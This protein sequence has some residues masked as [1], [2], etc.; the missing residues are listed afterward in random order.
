MN[1]AFT[2]SAFRAFVRSSDLKRR[3]PELERTLAAWKTIRMDAAAARAFA[4][5]PA[6]ARIR[7]TIYPSIKP[8]TNTFVWEPRTN[9]AIF[10]YLDPEISAAQFD[11]TLAHELHHLGVASVCNSDGQPT[12]LQ[13]M[14]GFAEG[15][16]VLAAAGNPDAHPHE[17]SPPVERTVWNRDFAN[18]ARDMEQL[19][20]FFEELMAGTLKEEQQNARGFAFIATDS[21]PQGA[22]YTVGYHMA[23]TVEKGLGRDRLIAS[24]CDPKMF[25]RDYNEIAIAQKLP[26]WSP[27]FMAR[28]ASFN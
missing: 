22:F 12:A 24:L 17:T 18:V 20:Q 21:V 10:F 15:R 16:A 7:A 2:D 3:A 11:N 26:S 4:Y 1:R 19:E 8:R 6:H 5:L 27:A 25:L 28:L 9:P 14:G 13:W 23:R